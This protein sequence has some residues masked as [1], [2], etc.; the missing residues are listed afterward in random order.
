M[1]PAIVL[2]ALTYVLMLTFTSC[3]H[4]QR[5]TRTHLGSALMK[6]AQMQAEAGSM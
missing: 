2:F 1:I 6:T 3:I 5:L 4:R